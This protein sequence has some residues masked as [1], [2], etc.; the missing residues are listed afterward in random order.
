MYCVKCSHDVVECCCPDI[1]ER[2]QELYDTGVGLA[3]RQ[4][5]EARKLLYNTMDTEKDAS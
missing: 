3:A 1:L 5:V 2:L 4:N